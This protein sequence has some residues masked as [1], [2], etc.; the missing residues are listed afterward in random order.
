MGN[1]VIRIVWQTNLEALPICPEIQGRMSAVY[2][3]NLIA[4]TS[5]E[6]ESL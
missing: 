2:A 4:I 3:S 5:F 6:E 1:I